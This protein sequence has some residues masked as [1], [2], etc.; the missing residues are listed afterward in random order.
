MKA[1]CNATP[2][3]KYLPFSLSFFFSFFSPPTLSSSQAVHLFT[4]F[5]I[6]FH[7]YFRLYH[8]LWH[9][10]KEDRSQVPPFPFFSLFSI[11]LYPPGVSHGRWVV[12]KFPTFTWMHCSERGPSSR[13][14]RE[15]CI[16][17][18]TRLFSPSFLSIFLPWEIV[19]PP[20]RPAG[21]KAYFPRCYSRETPFGDE[22]WSD[23]LVSLSPVLVKLPFLISRGILYFF[24]F[25]P[26]LFTGLWI[27]LLLL[28]LTPFLF[29]PFSLSKAVGA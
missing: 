28:L 1:L 9:C 20:H 8:T 21:P 14:G 4:T 5:F 22:W 23:R 27:L 25:W 24:F 13:G 29:W 18:G 12:V 19:L 26:S 7:L 2:G 10:G 15:H 11:L 17:Y 6:D 16:C 3:Y